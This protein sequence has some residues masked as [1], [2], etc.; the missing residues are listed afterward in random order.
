[1]EAFSTELEGRLF[2]LS[3]MLDS[4]FMLGS[5]VKK[6]KR[7]MMDL[8]SR[9]DHVRREREAVALRMDAVRSEHAREEQAGLVSSPCPRINATMN[10]PS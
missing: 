6:A 7:K 10:P 9:L 8:R 1:V 3:E 4:N 2:D 5:K